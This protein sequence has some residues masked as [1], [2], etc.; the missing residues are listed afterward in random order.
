MVAGNKSLKVKR[1]IQAGNKCLK[2]KEW[3]VREAT[4]IGEVAQEAIIKGEENWAGGSTLENC[5]V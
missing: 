2:I 1:D 5:N 4:G 3:V